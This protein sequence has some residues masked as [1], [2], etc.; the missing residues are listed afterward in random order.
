[1]WTR[2]G[3]GGHR[4]GGLRCCRARRGGAECGESRRRLHVQRRGKEGACV[5]SLRLSR[6]LTLGR[7][8]SAGCWRGGGG[9]RRAEVGAGPARCLLVPFSDLTSPGGPPLDLDSVKGSGCCSPRRRSPG[10]KQR[11]IIKAVLTAVVLR[12]SWQCQRKVT[13]CSSL[14]FS[15][16]PADLPRVGKEKEKGERTPSPLSPRALC[17][18]QRDLRA[19][20]RLE[21]PT[22]WTPTSRGGRPRRKH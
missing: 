12:T 1:M 9:A 21:S 3:L 17:E 20:T 19:V 10:E 18:L 11:R 7:R 2:R 4:A 6:V 5:T 13:F 15:L 14:A 8:G 16:R 22:G